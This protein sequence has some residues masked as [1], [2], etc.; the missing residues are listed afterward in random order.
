[1]STHNDKDSMIHNV[2]ENV[3]KPSVNI[4]IE[5]RN[6]VKGYDFDKGRDFDALL[7][8]YLNQGFQSTAFGE[9]V[10]EIK[11]MVSRIGLYVKVIYAYME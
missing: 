11:R 1:M 4:S 2:R 5:G 3:F 9:A 7:E 6:I 10:E 8:S